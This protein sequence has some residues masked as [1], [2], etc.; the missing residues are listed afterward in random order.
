[1]QMTFIIA[2]MWYNSYTTQFTLLK[3]TIQKVLVYAYNC[4]TIIIINF[5]NILITPKRNPVSICS[6]SPFLLNI[7]SP[8]QP[9]T[10][11]LFLWICWIWMFHIIYVVFCDW[12]HSFSMFSKFIHVTACTNTASFCLLNNAPSYGYTIYCYPFTS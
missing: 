7:F 10:Y 6:H 12:L 3:H 11:F 1:M 9:L 5:L 4:I 8:R 2:L